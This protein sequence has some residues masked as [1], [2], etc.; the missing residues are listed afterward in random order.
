VLR[1]G[2]DHAAGSFSPLLLRKMFDPIGRREESNKLIWRVIPSSLQFR[3][4]TSIA[5]QKKYRESFSRR[6]RQRQLPLTRST[7]GCHGLKTTI[8]LLEIVL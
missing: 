7:T 5:K 1:H 3:R 8:D 2:A 6:E 4:E